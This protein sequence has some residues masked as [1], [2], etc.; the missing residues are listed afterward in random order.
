MMHNIKNSDN[1]KVHMIDHVINKY[2][3]CGWTVIR[4]PNETINDLIAQKNNR[5]H[6]VQ[7]LNSN[8]NDSKYKDSA[9]NN[10]IQNAFSNGALPIH[11][12]IS[13]K[14]KRTSTTNSV[15]GASNNSASNNSAGSN[16]AS[17]K[18]NMIKIKLE[19]INSNN[20]IRINR[21]VNNTPGSH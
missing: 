4:S 16:S 11:A 12:T 20:T 6:F 21:T 18:K 17:N 13:I 19:D 14:E 9:R 10:F 8:D 1:H 3:S 15:N 2:T 7:V 5:L